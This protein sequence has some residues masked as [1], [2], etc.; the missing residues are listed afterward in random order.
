[1]SVNYRRAIGDLQAAMREINGYSPPADVDFIDEPRPFTR[2]MWRTSWS[3]SRR[4][5]NRVD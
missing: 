1:M 4:V 3:T 5:E 2:G